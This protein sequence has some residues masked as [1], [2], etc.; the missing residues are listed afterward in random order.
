LQ[1]NA[2]REGSGRW[3]ASFDVPTIP[4]GVWWR[5]DKWH[6]HYGKSID[7]AR[8]SDLRDLQLG[9]SIATLL[10]AEIAAAWQEDLNRWRSAHSC[11]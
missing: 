7:W 10:P 8:R 6:V 3:L 1:F 9:L 4:V 11:E 5:D 2:I